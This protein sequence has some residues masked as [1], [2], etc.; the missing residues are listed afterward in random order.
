MS[1]IKSDNHSN[2]GLPAGAEVQHLRTDEDGTD[3]Y[4]QGGDGDEVAIDPR[5]LERYN[6]SDAYNAIDL[7]VT[8]YQHETRSAERAL[9]DIA[10]IIADTESG[11]DV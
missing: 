9:S 11:T 6:W 1:K 5:D 8:A 4:T 2:H 10:A 3:W 7:I